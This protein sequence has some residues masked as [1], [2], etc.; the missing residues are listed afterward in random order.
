MNYLSLL[1]K[2]LLIPFKKKNVNSSFTFGFFFFIWWSDY[3]ITYSI[4]IVK[5]QYILYYIEY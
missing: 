3:T 1:D 5:L 4:I 2:Y